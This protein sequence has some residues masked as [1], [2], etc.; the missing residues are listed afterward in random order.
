MKSDKINC[1]IETENEFYKRLEKQKN[2][3]YEAWPSGIRY[4][5][6][7]L[8]GMAWDRPTGKG[9]FGSLEESLKKSNDIKW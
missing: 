7:V 9:K 2:N 8:D 4:D 6:Y 5:V 3:W 1:E